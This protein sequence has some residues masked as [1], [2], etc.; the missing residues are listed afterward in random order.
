M[1]DGRVNLRIAGFPGRYVQGPGAIDTLGAVLTDL[2]AQSALILCDDCV[3][4]NIGGSIRSVLADE[5][6][7]SRRLRFPGEC[8]RATITQLVMQ[9]RDAPASALVA[10]GGGKA[11]DTA[12]GIARA[13]EIPLVVAPT[14]ASNDAAT[15]RLIVLYDEMHR[16]VGTEMLR[17]NPAVVL[18]DTTLIAH[19]PVRYFRAGISD[20]LSKTFETAQ[21]DGAGGFNFFGGRPPRTARI[22]ADQAYR[23]IEEFG[24]RA[25]AAIQRQQRDECVE[26]V[27]EATVLHSGLGFESGGLSIAHALVRGLTTI[28]SLAGALHGEIVAFGTLVQLILEQRS[29][30]SIHHHLALLSSMGI[31]AT[32]TPYGGSAPTEHEIAVAASITHSASY[33]R[34]FQRALDEQD[35]IGAIVEADRIGGRAAAAIP[36]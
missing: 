20:A 18:V 9:A 12:K 30:A 29:I 27:T 14:I 11:I 22:L 1:N 4:A 34:N 3:E 16:F 2:R 23:T 24:P 25:V 10:L 8:T 13:I 31:A 5:Q 33:A 28:P 6:I 17:Q 32:L 15:S 7:T 21:C 36:Q 35:L 19:A 26:A